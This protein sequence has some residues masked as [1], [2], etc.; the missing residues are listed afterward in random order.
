VTATSSFPRLPWRR[1]LIT[2]GITLAVAIIVIEIIDGLLNRDT[3]WPAVMRALG[4]FLTSAGAAGVAAVIAGS[5]AYWAARQKLD[6]E[7]QA[8][9]DARTKAEEDAQ[10][11]R[12]WKLFELLVEDDAT[13]SI[14][15]AI[16]FARAKMVQQLGRAAQTDMQ[17][18]AARILLEQYDLG[19]RPSGGG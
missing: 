9:K 14:T 11:E 15:P 2:I 18:A 13:T 8:R 12:W 6:D 3:I 4:T 5:L 16:D 7:A 10:D 19:P 17:R 1:I